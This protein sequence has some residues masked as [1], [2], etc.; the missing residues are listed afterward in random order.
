MAYGCRCSW[1]E[2]ETKW[3]LRSACAWF[4]MGDAWFQQRVNLDSAIFWKSTTSI[5]EHIAWHSWSLLLGNWVFPQLVRWGCTIWNQARMADCKVDRP[6]DCWTSRPIWPHCKIFKCVRC[7]GSSCF[8]RKTFTNV[9]VH[10]PITTSSTHPAL[11]NLHASK[12]C[13]LFFSDA[14]LSE[15]QHTPWIGLVL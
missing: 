9:D 5:W 12:D 1:A 8:H 14:R 11:Y 6:W 2:N 10:Q 15:V 13:I 4:A 3:I 7:Y